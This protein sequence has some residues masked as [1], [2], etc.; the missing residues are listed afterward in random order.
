MEHKLHC[1][2]HFIDHNNAIVL[3]KNKVASLSTLHGNKCPFM[4][5]II[6]KNNKVNSMTSLI[7]EDNIS[8]AH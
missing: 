3:Y 6:N 4:T 2:M 7:I 5:L 1:V 8:D